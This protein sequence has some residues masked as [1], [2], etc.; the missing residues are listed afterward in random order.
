[1]D[2]EMSS[3][4]LGSNGHFSRPQN[5]MPSY[6]SISRAISGYAEYNKYCSEVKRDNSLLADFLSPHVSSSVDCDRAQ[7]ARQDAPS[8]SDQIDNFCSLPYEPTQQS[9]GLNNSSK[10]FLQKKIESLY[11]ESFAENWK[12]SRVKSNTKPNSDSIEKTRSPSCPPSRIASEE[13]NDLMKSFQKI[14]SFDSPKGRHSVL[15]CILV[16]LYS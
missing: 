7:I 15:G 10:S 8:Q 4:M 11:G 9:I 1:M 12:K 5:R 6:V 14:N 3:P 13:V 2:N 16:I